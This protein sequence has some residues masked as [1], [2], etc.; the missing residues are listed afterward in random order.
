M[1]AH[2]HVIPAVSDDR[3]TTRGWPNASEEIEGGRLGYTCIAGV[4]EVGRGSW[5]GPL[6]AAAVVLPT[7]SRELPNRLLGVRDSKLLSPARC[8]AAYHAIR[9]VARG[10]GVGAVS[11]DEIDALGL[12]RAGSV[13][14]LRALETLPDSP[15]FVIVDGFQIG[16]CPVPQKAIVRGDVRCVSVAAG[17]IVAKVIRDRWLCDFDRA[18][19]HYGFVRHKGYGTAEHRRALQLFGPSRIHRRSFAPVAALAGDGRR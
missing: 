19:P 2:L 15:D 10:V 14:M 11:H 7:L 13:A 6:V 18:F 17:S 8:L 12:T 3:T 9:D 16:G 4:D 1:T 5:A